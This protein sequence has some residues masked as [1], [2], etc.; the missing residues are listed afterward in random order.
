MQYF[1]IFCSKC[2]NV[3]SLK[4][5]LSTCQH[6]KGS[7]K[8]VNKTK[9]RRKLKIF[10][11]PAAQ[12]CKRLIARTKRFL[13]IVRRHNGTRGVER[14]S[15]NYYFPTAFS[16]GYIF[17]KNGNIR[18]ATIVSFISSERRRLE[19]KSNGSIDRLLHL[20][21]TI[22]SFLMHYDSVYRLKIVNKLN[23]TLSLFR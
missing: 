19:L 23:I 18:E 6:Q 8:L 1:A 12:W 15:C 5:K 21:N 11:H 16:V 7:T 14:R 2:K 20:K 9:S 10:P 22:F 3:F 4:R 13:C 17:Q